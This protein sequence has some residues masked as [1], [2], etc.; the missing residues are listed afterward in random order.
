MTNPITRGQRWGI[1]LGAVFVL[2]NIVRWGGVA[3]FDA[4]FALGVAVL[5]GSMLGFAALTHWL[6]FAPMPRALT[7]SGL[8]SPVIRQLAATAMLASGVMFTLA[9]AWDESWHRQ[10]GTGNDF[11]WMP[12]LLLYGSFGL[13]SLCSSLG[14]LFIAVRGQGG[15]RQRLRAEPLIALQALVCLFLLVSGPSDLLWHQIYG[16]DITAWSLPHVTVALGLSAVVLCAV[17]LALSNVPRQSWRG[18]RGITVS[19]WLALWL[20]ALALTIFLQFGTTEWEGITRVMAVV[21]STTSSSSA[22]WQRP[23]WLYIAVMLAITG[24]MGSF[25]QFT[26]KRVGVAT[27]I[28]LI[29]IA[30]RTVALSTFGG[31]EHRMTVLAQVL[32]LLPLVTLDLIALWRMRSARELRWSLTNALLSSSLALI[33]LMIGVGAMMAYPRINLETA[34][35]MILFGVLSWL[36]FTWVGS[37]LGSSVADAPRLEAR[38]DSVMPRVTLAAL[39]SVA[40]LVAFAVVFAQPPR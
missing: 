18:M 2:L 21:L 24:F 10:Y 6:L 26:L 23:E 20:C 40:V 16:R 5:S 34:P 9:A 1:L 3:K 33:A 37:L 29:V 32:A 8:T 22:F 7:T 36:A 4:Q 12:H 30:Q 19:E 14:L 25:A 39:S 28:G 35:W 17:T 15:I 27:L 11:W 38:P 31:F 13:C